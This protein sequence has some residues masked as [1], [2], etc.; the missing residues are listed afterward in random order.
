MPQ[1]SGKVCDDNGIEGEKRN[2]ACQ[3]KGGNSA[4]HPGRGGRAFGHQATAGVRRVQVVPK[5]GG[6]N[7]KKGRPFNAETN[8]KSFIR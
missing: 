2:N 1:W 6:K 4:Y 8:A 3:Q 7:G 5:R